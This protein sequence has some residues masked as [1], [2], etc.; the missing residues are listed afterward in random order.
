VRHERGR[1]RGARGAAHDAER[2]IQRAVKS[3]S[4]QVQVLSRPPVDWST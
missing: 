3:S 1:A 2:R 4:N